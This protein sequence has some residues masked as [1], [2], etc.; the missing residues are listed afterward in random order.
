MGGSYKSPKVF[1]K[2]LMA[3]TQDTVVTFSVGDRVRERA[4][5][6]L[7]TYCQSTSGKMRFTTMAGGCSIVHKGKEGS[8]IEY[9][10]ILWD[11]Q[12]T[13]SLHMRNRV[14]IET[15]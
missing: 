10:D 2:H 5:K 3:T 4:R 12:K 13:P 15:R 6:K 11:G 1:A 9:L 14:S 8:R 7:S